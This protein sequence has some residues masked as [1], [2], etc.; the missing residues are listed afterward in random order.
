ML[1]YRLFIR[2]FWRFPSYV[3]YNDTSVNSDQLSIYFLPNIMEVPHSWVDY[4]SLSVHYLCVTFPCD[5]MGTRYYHAF[6]F[7]FHRFCGILLRQTTDYRLTQY[8]SNTVHIVRWTI[9]YSKSPLRLVSHATITLAPCR[10]VFSVQ[11]NQK[12]F[13]I[14]TFIWLTDSSSQSDTHHH[15]ASDCSF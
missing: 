14:R 5:T 13:Y 7:R 2:Y 12:R 11:V 10:S 9:A 3:K 4:Y 15:T 8:V 1:S 6:R